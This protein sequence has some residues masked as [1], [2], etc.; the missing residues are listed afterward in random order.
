M[1]GFQVTYEDI[2]SQPLTS[3]Q[4]AA[5]PARNRLFMGMPVSNASFMEKHRRNDPLQMSG[6]LGCF[7]R[8]KQKESSSD[9]SRQRKCSHRSPSV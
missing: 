1:L 2:E 5:E 6:T 3:S 4:T 9:S 8:W 7:V